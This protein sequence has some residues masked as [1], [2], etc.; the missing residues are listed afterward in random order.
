MD[1]RS[2][3]EIIFKN[4]EIKNDYLLSNTDDGK[5]ILEKVFEIARVDMRLKC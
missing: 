3:S 2:Y 4:V 1:S 5:N